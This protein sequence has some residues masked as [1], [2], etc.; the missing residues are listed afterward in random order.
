[1]ERVREGVER[2]FKKDLKGV[3]E[4]SREAIYRWAEVMA[5]RFAHI[6]IKGLRKLAAEFGA[7][8]VRAFLLASGE[9]LFPE[10]SQ[11]YDQLEKLT[12]KEGFV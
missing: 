7:P 6:P 9:E 8:A 11:I 5:R 2:L 10:D 1:M 3:D 12:E 4:A